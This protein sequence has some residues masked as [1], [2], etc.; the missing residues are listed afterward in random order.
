[1][2]RTFTLD[3]NVD[4]AKAQAKYRDGVLEL[5][6]PKAANDTAKRLAVS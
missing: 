6:L 2:Y 3:R 1:M 4:E 5:T